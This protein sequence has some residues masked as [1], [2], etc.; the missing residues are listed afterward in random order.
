[1]SH[2]IIDPAT[3]TLF[4]D[5]GFVIS[6]DKSEE[7]LAAHFAGYFQSKQMD[8]RTN[9]FINQAAAAGWKL[10][11][12]LTFFDH[13]LKV[14]YI[15]PVIPEELLQPLD[16]ERKGFGPSEKEVAV[17]D[18]YENWLTKQVGGQRTFSWGTI[19]AL[20]T[21]RPDGP[22]EPLILLTYEN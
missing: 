16:A 18:I 11:L 22:G 7:T 4:L 15:Y 10:T 9:Y 6:P 17:L 2:S 19:E 8:D 12:N 21:P 5:D 1:M 3:G 20:F 14:V 13:R